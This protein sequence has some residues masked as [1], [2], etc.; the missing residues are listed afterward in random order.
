MAMKYVDSIKLSKS[1]WKQF[2]NEI[3]RFSHFS[4]PIDIWLDEVT[5]IPSDSCE[6]VYV[7]ISIKSEFGGE[8]NYFFVRFFEVR[9]THTNTM[10]KYW[11]DDIY[12]F[13]SFKGVSGK[14]RTNILKFVQQNYLV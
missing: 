8:P 10:T 11:A 9:P 4:K 1:T 14:D 6:V 5:K 13:K 7:P 12:S 3:E 2:Y